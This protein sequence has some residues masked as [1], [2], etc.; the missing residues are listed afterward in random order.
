MGIT[1][2]EFEFAR[3]R[4]SRCRTPAPSQAKSCRPRRCNDW[5]SAP[6]PL[7][8]RKTVLNPASPKDVHGWS[9]NTPMIAMTTNSSTSVNAER[10]NFGNFM[11][12]LRKE[13][14]GRRRRSGN[15]AQRDAPRFSTKR[16]GPY[17]RLR[18]SGLVFG[19]F[20][21]A[22][23]YVFAMVASRDTCEVTKS[24]H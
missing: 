22:V 5:K 2:S 17:S 16:M 4:S 12:R 8:A 21:L 3:A 19:A 20:R 1:A 18:R 23:C 9:S 10:R 11:I 15:I 14:G 13:E 7:V 6:T 24:I